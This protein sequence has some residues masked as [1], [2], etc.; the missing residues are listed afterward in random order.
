[1]HRT[2]CHDTK[3]KHDVVD[4]QKNI[5]GYSINTETHTVETHIY[6]L[7]KKFFNSFKDKNFITT[8]KNGYQIK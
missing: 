5:W 1:M 2:L 8:E 4:L 6:R 3:T 7:R